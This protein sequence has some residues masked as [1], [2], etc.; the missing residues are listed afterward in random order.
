MSLVSNQESCHVFFALLSH[1]F[2]ESITGGFNLA[3]VFPMV[4]HVDDPIGLSEQSRRKRALLLRLL[5]ESDCHFLAFP[6]DCFRIIV[7]LLAQRVRDVRVGEFTT[8][9]AVNEHLSCVF[10]ITENKDVDVSCLI[11]RSINW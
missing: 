1:K 8:S 5:P 7:G 2:V 10:S 3:N 9:V 6:D 11:F 4:K